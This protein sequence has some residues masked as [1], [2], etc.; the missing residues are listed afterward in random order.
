LFSGGIQFVRE[1]RQ[2]PSNVEG[3]ATKVEYQEGTREDTGKI[4][5]GFEFKKG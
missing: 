3:R 2:W 1:Q 5:K 4:R